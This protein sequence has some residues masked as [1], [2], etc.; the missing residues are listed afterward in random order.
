M[1]EETGGLTKAVDDLALQAMMVEAD[2]LIALGSILE[3]L[4]SLEKDEAAPATFAGLVPPVKK[5]VEKIILN[6]AA[7]R[8]AA[9]SL[10]LDG[11]R[12]LQ[13]ALSPS[14]ADP[15]EE[16]ALREKIGAVTGIELPAKEETGAALAEKGAEP[17]QDKSLYHDFISEALEHLETIEL[18]ILDLEQNPGDKECINAIFRPFHT[19]KGVSGFLNLKEINRFSHALESLLD[20]ARNGRLRIHQQIIDFVLQAVD[21]LKSMIVELKGQVDSGSIA[22]SQIDIESFLERIPHLKDSGEVSEPAERRPLGEILRNQG[23]VSDN[24]LHEALEKQGKDHPGLKVGEILIRENK[25]KPQ[26]VIQALRDQKRGVTA[27]GDN[28][29][30]VDTVKLDNLMDMIG[31]LVISETLVQQNPVLF[32]LHNEKLNRDLSQLRRITT[33]LQKMSMS[34]RMIPIR[35]TFQKMIRVV[36]D[37]SKKSGKQVDLVMS[38]EDTEIDRNTVEALYDPLVH[39]IRNAV[40]HGIEAPEER[41]AKG[42]SDTGQI[43]LRAFQ[44]S[45]YIVIEI[46]DDGQGLNREKILKKAKEKNLISAD[47]ALSDYQIWNLVFE[48]GFS[49]AAKVTD[50]SGRG[51]GM[52]VVK[53]A[54]ERLRGIVEINSTE[55]KG[56][57]FT[58]RVPL[59]LAIMDGIIIQIGEERYIVPLVF[60]KETLRPQ[61]KDL[62]VIQGRGEV[63][64]VRENLLPLVR[65]HQV[66]GVTPKKNEPWDALVVVVENEGHLKG[67]MVDDLIGKQEVVIKNLGE[68]LKAG[69]AVSGGTIMGDGRVGLIL[70]VH[71]LFESES[72]GFHGARAANA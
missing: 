39:M 5:I 70:D 12:V 48:P 57:R 14:G 67:L 2:D 30:K 25:V 62:T 33:E 47:A 24:D 58:M 6:E 19:V 28:T 7:D 41:K 72:G 60:I 1:P 16:K 23:V 27:A 32:G 10:V 51:V 61:Q 52:D 29:V 66:L 64:K 45:G 40:D 22:P 54:I 31:E 38:G 50:V 46:E 26:E 65:L 69:R 63:I 68:M 8:A 36:R 35:Q 44:K 4:E 17:I 20:E 11:I 43:L 21:L 53:K 59:T 13:R 9:L 18:K 3:K 15:D 56:C 34:L 42:K 49:T 37:L 55:G 71:G